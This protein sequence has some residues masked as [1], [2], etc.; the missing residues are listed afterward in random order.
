LA[1]E[2]IRIPP[3]PLEAQPV[4]ILRKLGYPSEQSGQFISSGIVGT[5]RSK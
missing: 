4:E 2:E 5:D 3:R 1:F